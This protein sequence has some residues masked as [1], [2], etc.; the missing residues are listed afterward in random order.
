MILSRK[1]WVW[2]LSSCPG[3]T[4]RLLWT[5]E[6]RT[7]GKNCCIQHTKYDP[8]RW[9]CLLRELPGESLQFWRPLHVSAV[10]QAALNYQQ[11]GHK[12]VL[13]AQ[14]AGTNAVY[15]PGKLQPVAQ[16][17]S[18]REHMALR[19]RQRHALFCCRTPCLTSTGLRRSASLPALLLQ[20]FRAQERQ[21]SPY[22]LHT[23]LCS[24]LLALSHLCY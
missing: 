18:D 19:R 22:L 20:P 3:N 2:F 5:P 9:H 4:N 14:T 13:H 21:V 24:F 12:E 16:N 11:Q 1:F 6:Q 23:H 8:V 7:T 15:F 10:P 17:N